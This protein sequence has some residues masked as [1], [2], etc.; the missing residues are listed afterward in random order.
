M[1]DLFE[2]G[3]FDGVILSNVLDVMPENVAS[4]LLERLARITKKDGYWFVKLNPYYA[5]E[6]LA[7]FGYHQLQPH[8]YDDQGVLRL[9][10]ESTEY[11]E[12]ILGR[13]GIIQD[14][15]EFAYPWQKGMNRLM[16]LK[17]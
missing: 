8:L 16:L 3:E 12:K 1:L 13:Y 5:Q 6:E 10:Q 14:Y 4:D 11:W 7:S 15:V 17:R 9:R 2:T